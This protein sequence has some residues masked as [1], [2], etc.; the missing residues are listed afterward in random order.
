MTLT[1]LLVALEA[2]PRDARVVIEHDGPPGARS[3]VESVEY[4]RS[5]AGDPH[6]L[7]DHVIVI[8]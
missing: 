6:G 5:D 3:H 8:G 1:E 2:Y 7:L 4:Q